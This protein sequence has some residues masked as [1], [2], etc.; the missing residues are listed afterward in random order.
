MCLE[1]TTGDW[2]AALDD[3][4]GRG[5]VSD[6]VPDVLT[7]KRLILFDLWSRLALLNEFRSY[8]ISAA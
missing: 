6:G 5:D 1:W 2:L 7:H 8:L 3:F 4:R